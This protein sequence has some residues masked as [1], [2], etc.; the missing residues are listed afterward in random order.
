VNPSGSEAK[1][2]A[3]PGEAQPKTPGVDFTAFGAEPRLAEVAAAAT[4]AH[5]AG[6][7]SAPEVPEVESW[8]LKQAHSAV[9]GVGPRDWLTG[10]KAWGQVTGVEAS[11]TLR[12]WMPVLLKFASVQAAAQA[13][14]FASGILVV[15]NL[16]KQEYA[17]YTLCNTMLAT[18]LLFADGGIGSALKAIGGRVWHDRGRLSQL[19][20][21]AMQL[22]RLLAAIILPVVITVLVWLLWRNGAPAGKIAMLVPIVLAG[23]GLELVTRVYAVALRLKSEV[24]QLQRQALLSAVVR[25]VLVASAV[26]VWFNIEVAILGVVSGFAVQ[27]WMM[28]NWSRPH[29]DADAAPDPEMRREIV[30]VVRKQSPHLAYYCVQAQITVWLISVFGSAERVAEVGALGRLA[31]VFSILSAVAGDVLFPAF[32]RTQ[33]PARVRRQYLQ[34]VLA[35]TGL[36]ACL[37]AVVALFPGPVLA[38]LGPQYR[39]LHREGV[40]MALCAVMG[41]MEGLTWELNITRAWIA[42]PEKFIP[43]DIA[44]MAVLIYFLDL[45]TVRGILMLSILSA[46]PSIAWAMG[47]AFFSMRKEQAAE[48]KP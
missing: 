1:L 34:M 44:V 6:K 32:A 35:F 4:V 11:A 45:S 36:C 41:V 19:I 33:D 38:V 2:I 37:L 13:I 43:F 10:A 17:L 24:R 40:L 21:T 18:V 26:T 12:R 23:C 7:G 16:P 3:A 9:T 47:F 14:G 22:R 28:R 8:G 15:R 48:V 20:Q 30:S 46:V 42:P 25:F 27:Y 5:A 31:V 39:N 29:L